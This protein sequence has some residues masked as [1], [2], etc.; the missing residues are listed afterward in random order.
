[1]TD[2]LEPQCFFGLRASICLRI[3]LRVDDKSRDLCHEEPID[4][5]LLRGGRKLINEHAA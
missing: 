1:M 5:A 4:R 3:H 2:G